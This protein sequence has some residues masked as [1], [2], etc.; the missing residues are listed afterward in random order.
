MMRR[1][2]GLI[3][4]C[5]PLRFTYLSVEAHVRPTVETS[6][7]GDLDLG[8]MFLIFPLSLALAPYCGID[9]SPYVKEAKSWQRWER[10]MMGLKVSPYLAIKATHLAFEVVYG[11]L[12]DPLNV[13]HWNKVILPGSLEY[14]PTQPK[15]WKYNPVTQG[16]AATVVAYVDDLRTL[17]LSQSECWRVMHR[18]ATILTA[19]G[20]QVA[21][22]KARAPTTRPGPWAGMVAWGYETGVCVR[23]TQVKWLKAK[24]QLETLHKEFE[25]YKAGTI[26]GLNFKQLESIRGFLVHMQLTYPA[27]TPYLRA[28]I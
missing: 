3:G 4:V 19:L 15:V 18:V 5:G 1:S 25:Q 14:D 9:L 22:R 28:F 17:G 16:L 23:A 26:A 8:E 2:L 21:G 6:W 11:D 10:L 13:F 24:A 12:R 20:I 27:L 7:M